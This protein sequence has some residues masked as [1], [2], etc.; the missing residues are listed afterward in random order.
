MNRIIVIG[1]ANIDFVST[2]QRIPSAG[3]TVQ[4]GDLVTT[5][6]G[7]GANQ[8]VAA[9]RLGGRVAFVGCLGGD[10]FGEQY[11]Q[12]LQAEGIEV[13]Q[14][15]RSER[16][17]GCALIAVDASG[18]NI[19]VCAPGANQDLLP[20]RLDRLPQ[21]LSPGDLVLLQFEVPM[22]T[23]LRAAK[24]VQ[25]AG[26]RVV[27]NPSPTAPCDALLNAGVDV[28]VLN[29]HEAA[30]YGGGDAAKLLGSVRE[31]VIVTHGA[32]PAQLITRKGEVEI[33]GIAVQPVDSV[34]A[35]DTFTGALALALA[36]GRAWPEAITFAH[37]AAAL[38]TL[39]LG[40]QAAMPTR[41]QV[42]LV[43]RA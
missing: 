9:A 31:A 26:G 8:A 37:A 12:H 19:I 23:N 40:A 30:H 5:F 21:L 4:G 38:S 1:S 34:G 28:L 36:E 25:E 11:L 6:G 20:H 7:K 2:V 17:N 24:L 15:A 41:A 32:D 10:A 29:E 33:P 3:E 18:A 22:E 35:G 14:V 16:P 43:V 42:E 39:S 13:S 27:L